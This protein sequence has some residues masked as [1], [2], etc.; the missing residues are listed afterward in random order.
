MANG[1]WPVLRAN[2]TCSER[3][4]RKP[5]G[6]A[7]H[8]GFVLPHDD[9]AHARP[10][11]SRAPSGSGKPRFTGRDRVPAPRLRPLR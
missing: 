5:S 9:Q 1:E 4:R 10:N 6:S 2:A 11:S 7:R 8:R 3:K